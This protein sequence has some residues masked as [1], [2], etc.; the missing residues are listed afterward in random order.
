MSDLARAIEQIKL[1]M[2]A[3][4]TE[5]RLVSSGNG[6]PATGSARRLFSAPVEPSPPVLLLPFGPTD[7]LWVRGG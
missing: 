4:N 2:E 6:E 5:L 1:E 7:T 3:G